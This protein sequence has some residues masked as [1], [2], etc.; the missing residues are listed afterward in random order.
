MFTVLDAVT[1]SD[2]RL[3]ECR[4]LVNLLRLLLFLNFF[5]C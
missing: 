1:F 5:S 4:L 2:L 3:L